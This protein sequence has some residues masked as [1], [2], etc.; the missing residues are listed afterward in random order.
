MAARHTSNREPTPANRAVALHC[1]KSILRTRRRKPA[2]RRQRRRNDTLVPSNEEGEPASGQGKGHSGRT[3]DAA[4]APVLSVAKDRASQG[5][6]G[7]HHSVTESLKA[8]R[9][10]RRSVSGAAYATG[11]VRT[12]TSHAGK[13]CC[14]SRRQTSFSRRRRRFL[15]T[16]VSRALDTTNPKRGNPASFVVQKMSRWGRRRRCPVVSTRRTSV[17]RTSRRERGKRSTPSD[18]CVL[19]TDGHGQ[20]LPP[21]FPAPGQHGTTPAIGHAETKTVLGNPPLI[22]RFVCRHHCGLLLPIEPRNLLAPSPKGK[23]LTFPH[24]GRRM[25][26]P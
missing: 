18:G 16:P 14:N 23:G 5:C 17:A 4:V 24:S 7:R 21:L 22:A 1:F 9:S 15:A 20:A 8:N 3:Y 25:A 2:R 13:S 12:T 10:V 11:R 26:V 6:S 19:R